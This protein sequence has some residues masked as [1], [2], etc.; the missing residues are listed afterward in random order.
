M[1]KYTKVNAESSQDPH[2]PIK[3]PGYANADNCRD[4]NFSVKISG[5]WRPY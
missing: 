1:S 3:N 5:A 2:P 4:L